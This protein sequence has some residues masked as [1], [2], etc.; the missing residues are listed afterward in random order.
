MSKTHQPSISPDRQAASP[1][2]LLNMTR[3][4]CGATEGRRPSLRE[5]E[6]ERER[7]RDAEGHQRLGEGNWDSFSGR[8]VFSHLL[9]RPFPSTTHS[10]NTK[11]KIILSLVFR[12][13]FSTCPPCS[14]PLCCV[15]STRPTNRGVQNAFSPTLLWAVLFSLGKQAL[16]IY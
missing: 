16:R 12:H 14:P 13:R 4:T 15:Q 2:S 3:R 7:E 9:F 5:R 10:K 6:R 1:K 11:P 8:M